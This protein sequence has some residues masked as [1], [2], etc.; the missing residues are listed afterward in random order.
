MDVPLPIRTNSEF[1]E[2][3]LIFVTGDDEYRIDGPEERCH[4]TSNV[5]QAN[6]GEERLIS[7]LAPQHI[8]S[9]PLRSVKKAPD[10]ISSSPLAAGLSTTLVIT[11]ECRRNV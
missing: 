10:T 3:V 6:C 7:L 1:A 8:M 5:A 9:A 4:T 2:W 11:G